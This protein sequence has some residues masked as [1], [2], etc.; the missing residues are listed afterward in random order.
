MCCLQLP[1]TPPPNTVTFIGYYAS[2]KRQV[3]KAIS[4]GKFKQTKQD[5]HLGASIYFYMDYEY[6][7]RYASMKASAHLELKYSILTCRVTSNS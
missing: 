5:D 3:N 6:A 7:R 2:T 1:Q 4:H